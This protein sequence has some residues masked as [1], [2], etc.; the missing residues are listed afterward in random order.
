MNYILYMPNLETPNHVYRN[1]SFKY[2][3]SSFWNHQNRLWGNILINVGIGDAKEDGI[4]VK[5]LFFLYIYCMFTVHV[6]YIV[7]VLCICCALH[8]N[9]SYY[10]ISCRIISCGTVPYHVICNM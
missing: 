6:L 1:A 10:I 9:I 2:W 7:C 8:H 3:V 4:R 5:F